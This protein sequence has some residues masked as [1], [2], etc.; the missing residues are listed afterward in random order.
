MPIQNHDRQISV[1]ANPSAGGT[2][3]G[4][5]SYSSGAS[6]T[7]AA[8]ANS[9]YSFVN[10]TENGTQVS[11]SASYTFT[12]TAKPRRTYIPDE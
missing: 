1:S 2:V 6:V 3:S 11:T 12:A 10:W 4:G 5:G 9:G 8:L 7:V